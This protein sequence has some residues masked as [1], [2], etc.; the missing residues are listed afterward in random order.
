MP[1]DCRLV[2]VATLVIEIVTTTDFI[3]NNRVRRRDLNIRRNGI[4]RGVVYPLVNV[5]RAEAVVT[6]GIAITKLRIEIITIALVAGF[7]FM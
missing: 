7:L 3:T 2:D 1:R 5:S 4:I 6:N